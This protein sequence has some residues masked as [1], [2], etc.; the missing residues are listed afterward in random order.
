MK[1]FLET[2]LIKYCA[3]AVF[4]VD[5]NHRV[6]HWNQA[7]EK[8]TGLP[9]KDVLGTSS[10][11]RPFYDVAR[12]C[13]CDLIIDRNLDRLSDLYP[14]WGKSTLL[15]EGWK[16]E[17]WYFV[18]EKSRYLIFD[19]APIYDDHGELVAAIENLHDITDR[20]LA[21]EENKLLARNLQ[22]AMDKVKVLSGL[23]PICA[24][25]KSIRDGRGFWNS[26]E[27]YL[28]DHSEARLSHSF[29]PDCLEKLYPEIHATKK[30]S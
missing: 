12:P 7:C 25:C 10:H 30:A 14:V 15:P 5:T 17:G 23:L 22:E 21:E 16:S 9:A 24:C 29:C 4:V 6:V 18:N 2:S 13:L 20:K 28:K 27:Q 3:V 11:W 26:I 8:L 1:D 19:A